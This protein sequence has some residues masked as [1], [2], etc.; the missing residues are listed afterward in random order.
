MWRYT[1]E[2]QSA[3]GSMTRCWG[4]LRRSSSDGLEGICGE[5]KGN[6]VLQGKV[7]GKRSRGRPTRQ[8]VY[9]VK[10]KDKALLE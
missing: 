10:E 2:L 3:L 8:W 1:G 9:V 4:L 6:T 5:V 7:E